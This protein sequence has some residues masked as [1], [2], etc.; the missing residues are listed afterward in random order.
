MW[1]IKSSKSRINSTLLTNADIDSIYP[2]AWQY[3][4]DYIFIV[5]NH[6]KRRKKKKK[7]TEIC[8]WTENLH[9]CEKT[10]TFTNTLCIP[11]SNLTFFVYTYVYKRFGLLGSVWV[12]WSTFV[13]SFN[14]SI[15]NNEDHIS[16]KFYRHVSIPLFNLR[17]LC[18]W[19][20][21]I[22]AEY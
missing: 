6:L 21:A 11:N 4:Q 19:I 18:C 5:Q 10:I 15:P 16:W 9:P 1:K 2:A 8:L 17:Y 14:C 20:S 22:L 3:I 7:K 12:H 13:L